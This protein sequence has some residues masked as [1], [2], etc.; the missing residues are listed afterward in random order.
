M[1]LEKL[2][3]VLALAEERNMRKAAARLYI[4]QPGLT[5]YINKLEHHLGVKLFDRTVS[6][7]QITE[8]GALYISKMKE[9]QKAEAIL[10]G[11][12]Q[13]MGAKRRT[14]RIGMGM[15][16]GMQWLPVL[17]PAFQ[18]IHPDVSIRIQEGSLQDLESGI[19]DNS[20]DVAFGAI[21]PSFSDISYENL[22]EELIYC[23][24]PRCAPGF[25]HLRTHE[26]TVYHP[27]YLTAEQLKDL[28]ILMPAP[29]NG[30]FQFTQ[31]M[32]MN[33]FQQKD[34][35]I[36]DTIVI[37]NL[38]T[39]YKLAASGCG[40]LIINAY[41]YHRAH[42]EFDTKLA[43]FLLSDPPTYRVSKIA[44]KPDSPNRE[45]IDTLREIVHNEL[46]PML[47]EGQPQI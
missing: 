17:L 10:R 34:L 14:L 19:A 7:I 38:D 31:N 4:S 2:D 1:T 11:Q 8:A 15:T 32:L 29:S 45:L 46:L 39:A 6:P 30:Y 37:S 47:N 35:Q 5:A 18:K 23:V 43:F 40:A 20:L 16:R 41:D 12:L 25:T 24:V 28:T 36:Q 42:P 3:Y 33:L 26:A 27:G 44:Y 9:L 21:T 22:R 13:D